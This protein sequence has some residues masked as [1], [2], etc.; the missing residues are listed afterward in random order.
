MGSSL[1]IFFLSLLLGAG[2][3]EYQNKNELTL[4]HS[5]LSIY[6]TEEQLKKKCLAQRALFSYTLSNDATSKTMQRV[7]N[8]C[9]NSSGILS[10]RVIDLPSSEISKLI[11]HLAQSFACSQNL[12]AFFACTQF[13]CFSSFIKDLPYCLLTSI[14]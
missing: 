5:T 1:L 13:S 14:P 2:D 11:S 7:Q 3:S 9:F 4:Q 6:Y 10:I 12:P 8:S